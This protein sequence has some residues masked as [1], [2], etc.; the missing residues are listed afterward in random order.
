MH[1]EASDSIVYS[2]E[3]DSRPAPL[4]LVCETN[5][6]PQLSS[7]EIEVLLAWFDADSKEAAAA[8]LYISAAT[9]ST[10]VTRIR[11]KY[12]ACGRPAKTKSSLFAR[13]VQDGHTRLEDW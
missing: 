5:D 11:A 8:R 3:I 12:A 6:K 4:R 10:H 9:V 1:T 13:A 2:D 7:R